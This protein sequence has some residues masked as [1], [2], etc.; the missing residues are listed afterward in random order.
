M[1]IRNSTVVSQC[2]VFCQARRSG[3]QQRLL[4]HR[5]SPAAVYF[6]VVVFG[7]LLDGVDLP[8]DGF[9]GMLE[10]GMGTNFQC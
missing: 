4:V 5:L 7:Q 9:E 6:D 3:L 10:C 2:K 8:H 1:H